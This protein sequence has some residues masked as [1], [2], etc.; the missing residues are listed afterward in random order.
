MTPDCLKLVI[1]TNIISE[2]V[3]IRMTSSNDV[4]Y[5][6]SDYA[7]WVRMTDTLSQKQT[8]IVQYTESEWLAHSVRNWARL[9]NMSGIKA[10]PLLPYLQLPKLWTVGKLTT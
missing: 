4:N 9:C 8:K 1:N 2:W 7:H 6:Q 3:T 10:D 5:I